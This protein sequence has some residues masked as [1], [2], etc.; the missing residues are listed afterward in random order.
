MSQNHLS[1]LISTIGYEYSDGSHYLHS[2]IKWKGWYPVIEAD[3]TYGGKQVVTKRFHQHRIRLISSGDMILNTSIYDQFWF[4]HGKF[5]QLFMPALYM[6]YR[7]RYTY[8]AEENEYDKGV[9]HLTGRLYFSNTFRTAYRDINP[10][11][12]QVIDLRFTAAPWDNDLYGSRRYARGYCFS[13]AFLPITVLFSVPAMRIRSPSAKCCTGITLP[14]RRGYGDNLISE[15]L[16]SFSADYTM[17]LFYPDLAAGS[18]LYLKR[19]RG[20]LFFD[21]ATGWGTYDY[22]ANFFTEG[23]SGFSSFGAELLADFYLL[24]L[25]FEMSAGASGGYIPADNR[26]FIKRSILSQRLRHRA[27]QK[28]LKHNPLSSPRHSAHA[29]P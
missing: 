20:S 21:G 15:K 12:G 16:F 14:I 13:P 2:G 19:I 10:R 17:P 7:N 3:I 9:V 23:Y 18:L 4:A 25:P 24:R 8:L 1:T 29:V 26:M 22:D 5:R 11:W 6:S 28:A 27:R